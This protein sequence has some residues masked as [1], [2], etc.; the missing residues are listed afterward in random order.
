MAEQIEIKT[1]L[2]QLYFGLFNK[3]LHT[4]EPN[5]TEVKKDRSLSKRERLK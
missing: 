1:G 5:P 3:L 4:Q 2:M